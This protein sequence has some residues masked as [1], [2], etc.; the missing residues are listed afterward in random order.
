MAE[1]RTCPRC[2]SDLISLLGSDEKVYCWKCD[3]FPIT[4]EFKRADK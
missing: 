3:D 4:P 1:K 2:G